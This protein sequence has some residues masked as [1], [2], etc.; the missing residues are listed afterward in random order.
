MNL[1]R[2]GKYLLRVSISLF[3]LF[4]LVL[5]FADNLFS[6]L[7]D[8]VVASLFIF[9]II[10]FCLGFSFIYYNAEIRKRK[11][12]VGIITM[13]SI[14]FFFFGFLSKY[15]S[16]PGASIEVIIASFLFSF[17][18]LP[19]IIKSRY[20]R[21]KSLLFNKAIILSFA[22]LFSI[23]FLFMGFLF[24]FVHW[25]G[26]NFLI[27]LGAVCL[28]ITLI[29]WNISYRKEVKLRL[30]AENR[31]IE[32][33]KEVEE[34]HQQIEEKNKEITDSINY[35][36][37][38]QEAILPPIDLIKHHFPQSFVYYQPK[39]IV[40]GDF[41]W[42]ECINDIIFIAAADCTG[43]GVPGALVSVVCSN[44]LNRSIKEFKLVEPGHILDKTRELVLDTFS[45]SNESIKDGMDIS[46]LTIKKSSENRELKWAGAN[47]PLWYVKNK[48]LTEIKANKQPI[49]K[50]YTSEF[51]VTHC[52]NLNEGD[53]LYLFSDGYADQ[54]GGP[55][56]KK[57]KYKQ[58]ADLLI[59]T[60]ELALNEQFNKLSNALNNWKGDL[61]QVDD[62][63]I[64]GIRL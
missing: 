14:V 23:I 19:L 37:R 60:Q 7:P 64:I 46:L 54:F 13:V 27:G 33:L 47:N 50:A 21:L 9:I 16:A 32:T 22:D 63:C 53:T 62:I 61:E 40:A 4:I 10:S 31:L 35:A 3:L 12:A 57:F 38:I 42:A 20:E 56:G 11:R 34:K 18:A 1:N 8:L 45:K 30:L 41:Y 55:K 2:V 43:H 24:S 49:G 28:T 36:K 29:S 26:A 59:S 15:L 52:L 25:P 17:S 58:F 5:V 39:A 51:Y 48:A 44:A 6:V